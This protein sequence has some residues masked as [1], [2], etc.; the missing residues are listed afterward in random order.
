[1]VH[2]AEDRYFREIAGF[3]SRRHSEGAAV[4]YEGIKTSRDS[5]H[6]DANFH[7]AHLASTYEF[8]GRYLGWLSGLSR[9]R[10]VMRYEPEWENH[11]TTR[12]LI[13]WSVVGETSQHLEHDLEYR[14]ALQLEAV[15]R[16]NLIE[17]DRDI[18]MLWG[19]GHVVGLDVGVK[20]LGY[21]HTSVEWLTAFPLKT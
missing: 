13:A 5:I 4:H 19:A 12:K 17:P 10:D 3:A 16:Q 8:M 21:E 7:T 9:Q 14:N 20:D 15:R 6:N 11:D 18:V 1:M 2:F